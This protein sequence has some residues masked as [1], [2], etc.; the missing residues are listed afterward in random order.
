MIMVCT[1]AQKTGL[2]RVRLF[3]INYGQ[4]FYE[5]TIRGRFQPHRDDDWSYYES[6]GLKVLHL[7][8]LFLP[9]RCQLFNPVSVTPCRK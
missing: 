2:R 3:V 4:A 5:V 9:Q 7:M 6:G 1:N 8:G